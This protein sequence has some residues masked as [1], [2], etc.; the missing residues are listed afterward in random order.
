MVATANPVAGKVEPAPAGAQA[1]TAVT[2]PAT[3]GRS[4]QESS[5]SPNPA[6]AIK[7]MVD[8]PEGYD[9]VV[10]GLETP[11]RKLPG[12]GTQEQPSTAPAQSKDTPAAPEPAAAAKPSRP[13]KANPRNALFGGPPAN[14]WAATGLTRA[15]SPR[16]GITPGVQQPAPAEADAKP[17]AGETGSKTPD[18]WPKATAAGPTETKAA[19]RPTETK[20]DD[21]QR[22]KPDDGQ[23]GNPAPSPAKPVSPTPG[24]PRPAA[25]TPVS[26]SPARPAV[27]GPARPSEPQR[28]PVPAAQNPPTRPAGSIRHDLAGGAAEKTETRIAEQ[29]TQSAPSAAVRPGPAQTSAEP[30]KQAGRTGTNPVS[31]GAGSSPV[32]AAKAEPAGQPL[33]EASRLVGAVPGGQSAPPAGLTKPEPAVR[34]NAEAGPQAKADSANADPAA[35]VKSDAA[36]TEVA[37][38]QATGTEA[39]RQADTVRITPSPRPAASIAATISA[40]K[41]APAQPARDDQASKASQA[42][43]PVMAGQPAASVTAGKPTAPVKPEQRATPT[44]ESATTDVPAEPAAVDVPETR[45]AGGTPEKRAAVDDTKTPAVADVP[46]EP[47]VD[48]AGRRKGGSL[49]GNYK[50]EV[51][52]LLSGGAARRR[53]KGVTAAGLPAP[54]PAEM[55]PPIRM[56]RPPRPGRGSTK[57]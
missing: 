51:A 15:D 43:A 34:L 45:A 35:L 48:E 22:G 50:A 19:A 24:P 8:V 9:V 1:K 20:P 54:D 4:P 57:E 16:V 25:P 7:A 33:T 38:P 52:E 5:G 26:P 55:E 46:A 39:K 3:A 53:R 21:G 41:S 37:G 28:E 12:N 32:P 56:T 11:D 18:A 2:E 36:K 42:A 29:R 6:P 40:D 44:A 17:A 31:A 14:A 47:A 27:P 23:R 30:A 49:L 13:A 10:V